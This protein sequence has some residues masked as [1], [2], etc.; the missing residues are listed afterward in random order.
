MSYYLRV[1]LIANPHIKYNGPRCF[2]HVLMLTHTSRCA[3]FSTQPASIPSYSQIYVVPY[4]YCAIK[5]K[6]NEEY[7]HVQVLYDQ[8]LP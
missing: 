3:W 1:T 4:V 6:S 7:Y 8:I 2:L 5:L